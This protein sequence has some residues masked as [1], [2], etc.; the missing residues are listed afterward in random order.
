MLRVG[1]DTLLICTCSAGASVAAL[2]QR[3][4][5]ATKSPLAVRGDINIVISHLSDFRLPKL[6]P[7][8]AVAEASS[9]RSLSLSG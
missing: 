6:A 8:L 2:D 3:V 1:L 7:S 5:H 4:V 9:G